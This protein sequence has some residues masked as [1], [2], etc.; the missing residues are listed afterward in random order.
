M[1]LSNE[2]ILRA[3]NELYLAM[4]YLF[5][6]LN[7]LNP[8]V[9]KS[10][11]LLATDGQNLLYNPM[12]IEQKS[13]INQV[14][15]N[16]AYLHSVL[17]CMFCHPFVRPADIGRGRGMQNESE[18]VVPGNILW[19][20]ACDV[21]VEYIIDGLELKCVQQIIPERREN[22][23]KMLEGRYSVVS[24]Q[25][26]YEYLRHLNEEEQGQWE[27]LETFKT[28]DHKYWYSSDTNDSD[29]NDSNDND[30]NS[31]SQND[32][33]DK[34]GG[35][36]SG[37]KL[38]QQ[39]CRQLN[40]KWEQTAKR[41]GSE[42]EAFTRT[43]GTVQASIV[44][45]L[46]PECVQKLSYREFLRK[47]AAVREEMH[48]D[49]DSFDYGF[50][51][52]GLMTYDNIPLIEELEYREE[53]RIEDFVIVL[54]T[55]GSCAGRVIQKF[56]DETFS[57][58]STEEMFA[59]RTRIHIIQ[60]DNRIQSDTV[61]RSKSDIERFKESFEVKGFGGTD[62]RPAFEYVK[63]LKERKEIS[64]MRGLLYFTDGH[65]IY[66]KARTAYKTAFI[67]A[68]EDESHKNVPPWAMKM[69]LG[70]SF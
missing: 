38:T 65:G 60:C 29:K 43:A 56:L 7:S 37:T 21:A 40:V 22:I 70:K 1:S 17:H 57:V 44:K 51:N 19:D 32:S 9:D 33:D 46:R 23:Y 48:A 16:R 13:M 25:N 68:E 6:P 10:T 52:Y 4:R 31:S 53:Q 18:S 41:A 30:R 62:F 55:S 12:M 45:A 27:S 11:F 63:S 54:D 14:L 5:L 2:S 26:V 58:L 67:F 50:Y 8:A 3:R 36:E 66:P 64:D 15:V 35:K 49:L 24:A 69:V 61:I 34:S 39:L 20:I 59:D 28:D 42:M 47:F